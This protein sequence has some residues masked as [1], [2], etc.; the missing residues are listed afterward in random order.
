MGL[1]LVACGSESTEDTSAASEDT[2]AAVE[3]TEATDDTAATDSDSNVASSDGIA[4]PDTS[5][6]DDSKKIYAYSWDDDFGTKL[7]IVLDAYPEYKDYVEIISLGVSGTDG[8]YQTNIDTLLESGDKYP[9]L[10]PADNDVAKY[11]SEDDSKTL[12]L[13]SIGFTEDML[14]NSYDFAKQYGTYNGELKCVTWQAS[15]GSVFYRRDI[16]QTVFG[17]DDPDEIQAKLADWD[18]FFE[19][20]D[21]LKEAGYAIVSGPDDI[22]Y[23]VWD[24]QSNPWVTVADDGSETL[25]LDSAV[26]EYLELAKKL[27][28]GGYTNET[29][30]WSSTWYV[31]M[32]DEG[33]TFCFF[34]CPWFAGTMTSEKT[35]DDGNLVAEGATVGNWGAVVGP[36]AYHWGGT[37]VS[38]GKDTP[39]PELCAFLLYELTCDPDI[40]VQITNQT[41]DC[42]NNKEANDRLINGEISDDNAAMAFLGGQNPIEVWAEAAET[43]DLSNVTYADSQIKSAI[44]KVSEAYNQGTYSSVD[45]A[46]A[47]LQDKVAEETGIAAE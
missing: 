31:Q 20:A 43:L 19:T 18:T 1:S 13:Y 15:P 22:K 24:T 38:V 5:D 33:N 16:A 17:T 10:I 7:S 3:D 46:I 44:D 37:Y 14:S 12:D 29:S 27:Y 8:T 9:S 11:Y 35:D 4:A 34:G 32:T 2:E 25:T 45:D 39:N 41:G 47:A 30:A 23:A 28:D 40:G 36:T 21:E 6:W 26:N 42:V